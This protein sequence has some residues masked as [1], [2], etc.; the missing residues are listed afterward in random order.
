MLAWREAVVIEEDEARFVV[1]VEGR[2]RRG[3][4][5]I[6]CGFGGERFLFKISKWKIQNQPDPI[7]LT[8]L[9]G[10]S[11]NEIEKREKES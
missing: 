11:R 9:I 7:L 10:G 4:G 1:V 2:E 8:K 5:A 6:S 3:G